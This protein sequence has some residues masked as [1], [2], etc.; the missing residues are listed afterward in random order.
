MSTPTEPGAPE[1]ESKETDLVGRRDVD[2]MITSAVRGLKDELQRERQETNNAIERAINNL[3]MAREQQG[4]DKYYKQS[5]LWLNR[6]TAATA[7]FVI[8]LVFTVALSQCSELHNR[9]TALELKK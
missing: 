7:G 9:I 3:E 1:E 6:I 4:R 8:C 2:Q 5:E